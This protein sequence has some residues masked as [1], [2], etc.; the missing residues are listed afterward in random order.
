MICGQ[1]LG[2]PLYWNVPLSCVPPCRRFWGRFV[3]A[4]RL[5][6][7]N[8]DSPLFMFT[9]WFGTRLSRLLQYAVLAAFIPRVSHFAD[10]SAKLPSERTTP[11]SEPVMNCSGLPGTVTMACSSGCSPYARLG[12]PS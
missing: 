6:N 11:P 2:E 3:L 10:M 7:C 1:T 5:W 12:S 8:V 4:D 9:S